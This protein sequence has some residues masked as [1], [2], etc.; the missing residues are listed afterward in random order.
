MTATIRTELGAITL[1][2]DL[3]AS[4]AGFAA[5]EN[6]GIVGMNSKTAGD[7]LLQMIG[8]D[9]VR[10]PAAHFRVIFANNDFHFTVTPPT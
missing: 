7:T 3:I 6:Y 8:G 2:E 4:I 1:D 5:C 9:N 10:R